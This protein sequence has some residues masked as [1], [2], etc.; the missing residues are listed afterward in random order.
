MKFVA[1]AKLKTEPFEEES[2][3]L[4]LARM[5]KAFHGRPGLGLPELLELEVHEVVEDDGPSLP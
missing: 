1:V 5:T 3:E 4:A 2:E